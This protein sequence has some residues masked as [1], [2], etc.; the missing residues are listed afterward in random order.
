MNPEPKCDVRVIISKVSNFVIAKTKGAD[1]ISARA[2]L[3]IGISRFENWHKP[4]VFL[5]NLIY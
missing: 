5:L 3:K 2:D 4:M 1:F